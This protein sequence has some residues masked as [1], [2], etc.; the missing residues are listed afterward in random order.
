M[1]NL[2]ETIHNRLNLNQNNLLTIDLFDEFLK[3][4]GIAISDTRIKPLRT[5]IKNATEFISLQPKMDALYTGTNEQFVQRLLEKQLIIPEFSFF[6]DHITEISKE[7]QSNCNGKVAD[8]IPELKN[9][10]PNQFAVSICTV[11]GQVFNFGDHETDFC[12][13]STAKPINY[14]IALES[15]GE[16][17]VH[18]H[19]GREPSGKRFNEVTLNDQ[20]LP[21]NPLINAGGMMCCALIEPESSSSLRLDTITK[22]WQQLTR[23]KPLVYDSA[24]YKSEKLTAH[25]NYAL[26][27]LMKEVEAFPTDTD[28][29][30]TVDLY[31][32]TCSLK[33][34]TA[35]LAS[36]AAVIA[37]GGICPFTHKHIFSN[38]T[39]KDCLTMMSFCGMYDFSGEFAFKVGIPAKS[40]VSGAVMLIIPNLMGITIW[41]PNL[42]SFGN[43]VRGVEF[44]HKL[45]ERFNFHNFDSL[46]GNC[47]KINPRIRKKVS[48]VKETID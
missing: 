48:K 4:N 28:L 39:I 6:R 13:Q 32:K 27:H 33:V 10:D 14:A 2:L 18:K 21:H 11:D 24:V 40:G 30:E 41:S 35:N 42:D 47:P 31:I 12:L 1:K 20:G 23:R 22:V 9:I 37:N 38:T 3:E 5:Y 8:Y 43:S 17:Y 29:E 36:A 46:I 16:T 45:T 7:V 15:Q 26:A 34:N 44:A 19:I 25:R